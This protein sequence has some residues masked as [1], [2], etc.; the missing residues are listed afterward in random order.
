[1]TLITSD[2]ES[3]EKNS[4][5]VFAQSMRPICRTWPAAHNNNLLTVD[6]GC[7]HLGVR[8]GRRIIPTHERPRA[9]ASPSWGLVPTGSAGRSPTSGSPLVNSRDPTEPHLGTQM[10]A[11][12][13]VYDQSRPAFY[14]THGRGWSEYLGTWEREALSF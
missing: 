3:P 13:R 4:V 7:G 6:L 12:G 1:M 14:A 5:R 9:N 11:G 10:P 8:P 2:R